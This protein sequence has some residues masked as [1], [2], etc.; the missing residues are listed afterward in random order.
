MVNQALR[1][2]KTLQ[3]FYYFQ[4]RNFKMKDLSMEM[5][6]QNDNLLSLI[7]LKFY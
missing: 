2:K 7:Y 3:S 5:L 6:N 1:L 4:Q